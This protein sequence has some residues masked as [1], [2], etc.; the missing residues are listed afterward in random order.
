MNILI[1]D[2]ENKIKSVFNS[3]KVLSVDSVYEKIDNSNDLKLVIFM[4]KV[5]YNDINII[6]TKLIFIVNGD[7]SKLTK[8]YFTYLYDINC[9]YVRIEFE[10]LEDFSKKIQNIFKKKKFGD[11]IKILSKFIK[12]PAVLVNDWLNENEVSDLSVTGFK[13]EPKIKIMPCKSLFFSFTINLSN[14][15]II[16]L[17]IYKEKDSFYFFK[18]NILQKYF[19]VEQKNLNNLV[20]IVGDALKNK[21]K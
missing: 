21:V 2:L 10:D 18:F 16:D 9:E 12:S 20:S 19:T 14:N 3:T 15:Q 8:N 13:Y 11:D 1:S 17:E 4:N 5:L 7:K 6:Y